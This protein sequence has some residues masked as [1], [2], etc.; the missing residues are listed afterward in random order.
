MLFLFKLSLKSTRRYTWYCTLCCRCDVE[1]G[2]ENDPSSLEGTSALQKSVKRRTTAV[3]NLGYTI[4]AAIN[5]DSPCRCV[6]L[7]KITLY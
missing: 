3:K 2:I 7:N 5:S 1:N 6:N 4:F